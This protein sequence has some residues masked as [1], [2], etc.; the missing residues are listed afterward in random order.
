MQRQLKRD[1]D[2][3]KNIVKM[4]GLVFDEL[5]MNRDLRLPIP[6]PLIV[7]RDGISGPR[8]DWVCTS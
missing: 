5:G 4:T 8:P 1:V 7:I 3:L 2:E 6:G